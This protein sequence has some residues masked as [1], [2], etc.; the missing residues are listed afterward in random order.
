MGR[1][2]DG[3]WQTLDGASLDEALR[4]IGT[5]EASLEPAR[6]QIVNALFKSRVCTARTGE[7][8]SAKEIRE[9]VSGIEKALTRLGEGMRTLAR[10]RQTT[11]AAVA[12][13][14]AEALEAAHCLIIEEICNALPYSFGIEPKQVAASVPKYSRMGFTDEWGGFRLAG[15]SVS[16]KLANLDMNAFALPTR[17]P[18]IERDDLIRDLG[19]IYSQVT[20]KEPTAWRPEGNSQ[21]DAK[22]EF[23]QFLVK[24]WHV[25]DMDPVPSPAVINAALKQ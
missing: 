23:H 3:E 15:K 13:R 1:S 19:A 17:M 25:A 9:A 7:H 24:I 22:S 16:Q 10:A 18:S 12:P 20:G 2:F 14:R 5:A 11:D 6:Q 4:F 8:V 21:A